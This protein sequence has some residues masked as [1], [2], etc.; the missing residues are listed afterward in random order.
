MITTINTSTEPVTF[1]GRVIGLVLR[2]VALSIFGYLTASIASYL[3][4]GEIS[5]SGQGVVGGD[6]GS[7]GAEL[8]E[9]RRRLEQ[10]EA[11][12]DRMLRE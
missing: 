10:I 5:G 2:V 1:E 12:L 6:A 7:Y 3:V 4:G 11:R 9:I 8:E